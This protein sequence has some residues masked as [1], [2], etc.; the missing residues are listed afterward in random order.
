MSRKCKEN[1]NRF[2]LWC[3]IP[4]YFDYAEKHKTDQTKYQLFLEFQAF[5]ISNICLLMIH[6][7]YS[8]LIFPFCSDSSNFY[9]RYTIH[10]YQA[11]WTKHERQI[12]I[13]FLDEAWF[14]IHIY[15][16]TV[17]WI[18]QLPCVP[19][20]CLVTKIIAYK[21]CMMRSL[22]RSMPFHL[23]ITPFT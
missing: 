4:S 23:K 16:C 5:W 21:I 18:K 22:R 7:A 17:F 8:S 2:M 3:L 10:T 20:T 15:N 1:R 13:F 12:V 9:E 11:V 14:C 6:N 19:M